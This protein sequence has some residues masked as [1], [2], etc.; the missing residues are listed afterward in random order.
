MGLIEKIDSPQTKEAIDM[1]LTFSLGTDLFA[2]WLAY[3]EDEPAGMITG[4]VVNA[5]GPTVFIA[6]NYV[7][8]GVSVNGELVQ[9]IE[10]WAKSMGANKL[11]F[12][13]KKSPVTFI[14]KYGFELVQSVLKKEITNG[15]S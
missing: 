8:P 7:K 2:A 1:W 14:K 9:K 5:D 12:Y 4:E 10:V 6:F 11:L 13:T 15:V 3:D